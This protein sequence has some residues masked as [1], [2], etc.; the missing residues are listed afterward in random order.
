MGVLRSQILKRLPNK[1]TSGLDGIPTIVL[2]HL[3][4]NIINNLVIIFN[5]ALNHSYF[6]NMWKKIKVLP[7]LKKNKDPAEPSSYRPISL[8][9]MSKVYLI[10]R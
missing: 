4:A 7:I 9:T 6:T 8:P 2:K 10:Y 1:T 3:P 5:N